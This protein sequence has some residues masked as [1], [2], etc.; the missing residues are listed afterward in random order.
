MP[1]ISEVVDISI[2][3]Q[4]AAVSQ[5]SFDTI[6]INGRGGTSND[7]NFNAG[8]ANHEVRQYNSFEAVGNDS[9]IKP[10]ANVVQMA[11]KIFAQ[12]PAVGTIYIS[13]SDDGTPLPQISTLEY[14]TTP[15]VSGQSVE[16]SING[17]EIAAS[18]IAWDTDNDTTMDA[19]A[20]AIQAESLVTSAVASVSAG[21]TDKDLITIT[22]ATDGISFSVVSSVMTGSTVDENV[23]QTITQAAENLLSPSD[24]TA[25]LANNDAW[26]AYCHDFTANADHEIAAAGCAASNKFS[27]FS[28]FGTAPSL[29]TD[30]AFSIYSD[31]R[32]E[33]AWLSA[34]LG[35]DIG[36]YNPAYMTLQLTDP[37]DVTAAKETE[38][39]EA[40]ANQYSTLAGVDITYDGK[41]SNGGW[42]DTNINALWL[43]SRLQEAVFASLVSNDKLP[44]DDAGITAIG[45]TVYSVLQDAENRGVLSP[46]PKFT[47][48][49]PLASSVSAV[50]RSNRILNGITFEAYSGAGINKVKITGT[51]I[52]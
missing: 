14:S 42:I 28:F 21:S 41:A 47:V 33:C 12:T 13:R 9:D 20:A 34:M 15:L 38:L 52:D 11:Q 31:D 29:G 18:P 35:K 2:S 44:Y 36:S 23:I 22:G 27:G 19:V 4:S 49:V 51:I 32:A 48:T 46:S 10:N 6:L 25:I 50:D 3:I 16:V 7:Q 40:N 1:E 43:E 30:R 17:D 5:A 24:I 37:D 8:F 39:R 26:F 45:S